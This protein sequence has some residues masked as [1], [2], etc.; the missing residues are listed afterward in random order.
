ML[1]MAM[2]M[3]L[4]PNL[5]ALGLESFFRFCNNLDFYVIFFIHFTKYGA[6]QNFTLN[7]GNL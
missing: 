7:T 3:A 4:I 6:M 5:S 1:A 2:A